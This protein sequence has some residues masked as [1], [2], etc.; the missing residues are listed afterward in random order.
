LACTF[1]NVSVF[2]V[3]APA[4]PAAPQKDLEPLDINEQVWFRFRLTV[5]ASG[6]NKVP[7]LW[8]LISRSREYIQLF[9]SPAAVRQFISTALERSDAPGLASDLK[10]KERLAEACR[11]AS[12][13][14][15]P[16]AMS[17]D[18]G[19]CRCFFHREYGIAVEKDSLIGEESPRRPEGIST[20]RM[21]RDAHPRGCWSTPLP[22]LLQHLSDW[23]RVSI[24]TFKK[25]QL[26][27]DQTELE[28]PCSE[29]W[30]GPDHNRTSVGG[31]T[32]DIRSRYS[33]PVYVYIAWLSLALSLFS[34]IWIL[35]H[36]L[37]GRG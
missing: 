19:D 27:P 28:E 15:P 1:Y 29:V 24:A 25:T 9:R 35:L 13:L 12:L 7:P 6:Y 21:P 17:D 20:Y 30:F 36:W 3:S 14:A 4:V 5:P 8:R 23:G 18:V 16:T 33:N 34:F 2:T 22:P 26:T 10:V 31:Y 11:K 32:I 37:P